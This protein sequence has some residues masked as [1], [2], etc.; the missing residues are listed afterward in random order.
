M[1]KLAFKKKPR[2]RSPKK[3]VAKL[4]LGN[5]HYHVLD[6]IRLPSRRN[7]RFKKAKVKKKGRSFD[8]K[9]LLFILFFLII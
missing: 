2:S 3:K 5:F 8:C 1:E 7:R 6:E 4:I 9:Q